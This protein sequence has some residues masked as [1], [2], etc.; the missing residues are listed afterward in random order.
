MTAPC[1]TGAAFQ[2]PLCSCRVCVLLRKIFAAVFS[3]DLGPGF[4]ATAGDHLQNTYLL[5]LE[6]AH[7]QRAQ[8][9]N[10]LLIPLNS[11][12]EMRQE[13]GTLH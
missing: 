1:H 5:I 12:R 11:P 6:A 3:T 2:G 7:L 4:R 10:L 8:K 9:K 13:G